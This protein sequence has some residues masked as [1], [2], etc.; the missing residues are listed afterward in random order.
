M[1]PDSEDQSNVEDAEAWSGSDRSQEQGCLSDFR[2]ESCNTDEDAEKDSSSSQPKECWEM[3]SEQHMSGGE[4][5][6][7]HWEQED[8]KSQ[9]SESESFGTSDIL[10]LFPSAQCPAPDMTLA[11]TLHPGEEKAWGEADNS[12]SG[13]TGSPRV[14]SSEGGGSSDAPPACVSFGISEEGAEQAQRWDFGSDKDLCRPNRHTARHTRL[15]QSERHV[16]ETKS[17]CKRIALLLTHAPNPRNKGALLFKKRRQRV[18]NYTFTSYGTGEIIDSKD[19]TEEAEEYNFVSTSD[20]EL[21][22]E[23]SVYH[24]Q[25]KYNWNWKGQQ[26]MEGLSET[27]GKGAVMFAQRRKRMDEIVSEH[28]ELRSKGLPVE[29][30]K[31]ESEPTAPP[32][33]YEPNETYVCSG[34]DN[35]TEQ[36]AEHQEENVPK[37]L[38]PNRTAKPFLGFQVNALPSARHNVVIPVTP[39]KKLPEPKFKVPVHVPSH[40]SP[41]VWSPTGEI[42]ASRDERISV[43][44]I[45]TGILPEAKRKVSTKQSLSE[46]KSSLQNQGD[47]RSFIECE[48]D[49]FSL[50][51]EACNFMQPKTIKLKNPPPVAPKPTINPASLPWMVKGA[52][53]DPCDPPRIAQP[54]TIISSQHFIQQHDRAKPQ[55]MF[56]QQAQ[57]QTLAGLQTST[58]LSSQPHLQQTAN[59]WSHQPSRSPVSMKANSPTYSP[60]PPLPPSSVPTSIVSCP[61]PEKTCRGPAGKGAKLFAKRQSR[62]EKFVVGTETKQVGKPRAPSPTASLP[63]SWRYSSNIRAPPPIAYNPLLAPFYPPAAAKQPP[64]TSPKIKPKLT[65][66]KPKQAPKHLDALDI[67]KHQPYHLDSSLFKYEIITK[68]KTPSPKSSP[69]PTK[70]RKGIKQKLSPARSPRNISENEASKSSSSPVSADHKSTKSADVLTV[71]K[72]MDAKLTASPVL[73]HLSNSNRPASAT[74]QHSSISSFSDNLAAAFSPASLIA[75]G[76]RQMAPRPKF[77]AKKQAAEGKQWK[78]VALLH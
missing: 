62:M 49:F 32:N 33:I 29:G 1:D 37:P 14:Q 43:P 59:G 73:N 39:V 23:Y 47:R 65:K 6:A 27:Q 40:I 41:H 76:V 44:A 58:K 8:E 64:S 26:K 10:C 35:Y 11:L 22:E 16:K 51:A 72:P 7:F 63:I 25:C 50:G 69:T 2:P 30:P 38:V 36:P 21:E 78:P 70:P 5:D 18:E 75:R 60:Q 12:R 13:G 68:T 31:P 74:S 61:S 17:K 42:I 45:R 71:D 56:N 28:D 48:E 55:Q 4:E 53:D 66:S 46:Q 3:E 24:Q 57:D 52:L 77:F 67:M 20:S 15:S 34:Q 9:S 19:Q 54:S